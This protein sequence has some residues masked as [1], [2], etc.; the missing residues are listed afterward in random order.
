MR[1]TRP[2]LAEVALDLLRDHR[3][4]GRARRCSASRGS[5]SASRVGAGSE[6]ALGEA[7]PSRPSARPRPR[8]ASRTRPAR[9]RR[10]PRSADG[11]PL[12][13]EEKRS[14]AAAALVRVLALDQRGLE[15]RRARAGSSPI[16]I[17]WASFERSEPFGLSRSSVSSVT[18]G[19][20][21][22]SVSRI[23]A[24]IGLPL[25]TDAADRALPVVLVDERDRGRARGLARWPGR[26][27]WPRRRR[28]RSG[29]R[30]PRGWCSSW[31][32][33]G[34]PSLA[35]A[36]SSSDLVPSWGGVAVVVAQAAAG[37]G[38]RAAARSEERCARRRTVAS[39]ATAHFRA[40]RYPSVIG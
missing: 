39:E 1:R 2:S 8:P 13:E 28:R 16:R 12:A 32:V 10:R 24:P 37:R 36:S 18:G 35:A 22:P 9:R 34:K 31:R 19:S 3:L 30:R 4:A 11:L 5:R 21:S 17:T 20:S 7:A 25:S 33:E 27:R 40:A 6:S 29:R 23:G 14:I 38:R 26:R 15:A